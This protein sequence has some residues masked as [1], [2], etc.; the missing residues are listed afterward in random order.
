[1]VTGLPEWLRKRIPSASWSGVG[2][3]LD[4]F[5]KLVLRFVPFLRRTTELPKRTEVNRFFTPIY[6]NY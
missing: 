1:M 2:S 6:S 5:L 4:S 3:R